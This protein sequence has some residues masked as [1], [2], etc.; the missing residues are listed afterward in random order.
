VVP[1]QQYISERTLVWY[2][3]GISPAEVNV[4]LLINNTSADFT[5]LGS[6]GTAEQF[7]TNLV[8]SMDQS[9]KDRGYR[10]ANQ[11]NLEFQSATLLDAKNKGG[12]YSIEYLMKKPKEEAR[13]LESLVA[14][15]FDGRYNRLFTLTAQCP[16]S[17]YSKYEKA[18]DTF[19][20]SFKPPGRK[21]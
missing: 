16:E 2:P 8:N 9:Y 6:F 11:R 19:L 21:K 7:G 3:K 15:G 20:E 17:E 5:S 1:D 14:L 4:S 18:I 12:I 13:R 10:R